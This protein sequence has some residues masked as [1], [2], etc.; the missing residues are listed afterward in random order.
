M[1]EEVEG[2]ILKETPY[3]ETS[4]VLQILTKKYG[5]VSAIAKGA[6]SIKSNLRSLTI[7]FL[8]AKF[9]L[10]YKE[11]KLSI[12]TGGNI[13]KLYGEGK[14]DL[15]LYAYMSYLCDLSYNVLK[16][17]NDREIFDILKSSLDKLSEKLDYEVI[18]NIVEF[19]YLNYLGIEPNFNICHKCHM[20]KDFYAID[21]KIGG[22]VCSDCF[23]NERLITPNLL[24]KMKRFQEVNISEITEI[25]LTDEEKKLISEFLREYYETFSAVYLNSIK[26]L[27]MFKS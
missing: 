16:E 7:P 22:F 9:E 18:K 27:D 12:L 4:K 19:K 3:S 13:I 17:N 6:S 26:F 25:K 8:Y 24:K 5:L 23:K 1:K 2:I 21:G 14:S 15:K 11:G 10:I 20:V